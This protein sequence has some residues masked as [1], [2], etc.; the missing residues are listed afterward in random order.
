MDLVLTAPDCLMAD[1]RSYRCAT[2]HG[3]ISSDK[4]EGDGVTPI[5]PH[6]LRRVYFRADRLE[7]PGADLPVIPLT[8]NDGWC[9][10]PGDPNYNCKVALP[11]SGRHEELWRDDAVYDVIVELGYNDAP[12]ISGAGSAIFLHVATADYRPTE[13]CVAV[14]LPDLLTILKECD[15]TTILEVRP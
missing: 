4:R 11:Y 2:G 13:G 15:R 10:E 6:P 9:D 7:A 14:A 1:G 5:G 3:G 12:A 8:P